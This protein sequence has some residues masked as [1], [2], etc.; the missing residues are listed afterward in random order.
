MAASAASEGK[1]SLFRSLCPLRRASGADPLTPP[2]P[3]PAAARTVPTTPLLAGS[4]KV[5]CPLY[6]T[7]EVGTPQYKMTFV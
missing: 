4:A 6:P 2:S 7:A 5:Q 1:I 3:P